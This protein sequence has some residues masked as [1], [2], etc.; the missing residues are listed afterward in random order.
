MIDEPVR[1]LDALLD[2]VASALTA[3]GAPAGEPATGSAAEG[4]VTATVGA[5]GRVRAISLDPRLARTP[6]IVGPA[7]AEAVNAARAAAPEP[8]RTPVDLGELKGLQEASLEITRRLT[9]SLVAS[10]ERMGG[11]Q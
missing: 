9:T 5:D 7:I 3:G 10:V 2:R 6:E 4:L 11:P 8:P 1:A